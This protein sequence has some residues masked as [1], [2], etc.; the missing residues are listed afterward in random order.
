MS[1]RFRCKKCNQKYEL[2]DDCSGDTLD[3]IRCKTQMVVPTES[4]IPAND[5]AKP[6]LPH[7]TDGKEKIQEIRITSSTAKNKAPDDIL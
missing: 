6:V 1:I 4:E 5:S 3:C 7:V 2:D